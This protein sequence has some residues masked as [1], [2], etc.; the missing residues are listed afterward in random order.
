MD[1]IDTNWE[2]HKKDHILLDERFKE[3]KEDIG[4]L[5]KKADEASPKQWPTSVK[6][7]T[8]LAIIAF[9]GTLITVGVNYGKVVTKSE[10][11]PVATDVAVIKE[12][13][14]LSTDDR[15]RMNEKLDLIIKHISQTII[16]GH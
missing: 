10:F 11:D 2:L 15:Q 16:K 12:R 4:D 3:V 13:M 7:G 9:L 6:I 14:K 5:K 8:A 1:N